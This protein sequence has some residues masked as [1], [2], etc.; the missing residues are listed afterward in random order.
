MLGLL[1]LT[2]NHQTLVSFQMRLLQTKGSG[3]IFLI[4]CIRNLSELPFIVFSSSIHELVKAL[5]RNQDH[6]A[7]VC[8][9]ESSSSIMSAQDLRSGLAAWP[10]TY[11]PFS[12]P[13]EAWNSATTKY[14][15]CQY[16]RNSLKHPCNPSGVCRPPRIKF[17][18]AQA[19]NTKL[20]RAPSLAGRNCAGT[21]STPKKQNTRPPPYCLWRK[22]AIGPGR[23]DMT[24]WLY[25]SKP[26]VS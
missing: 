3:G 20:G 19:S 13:P 2:S 23:T 25:V 5:P 26:E 17:W 6:V 11:Y 4:R 14:C 24:T 12:W 7:Q 9:Q 16:M 8:W 22:V 18:C 10:R 15:R 21:E 1:L